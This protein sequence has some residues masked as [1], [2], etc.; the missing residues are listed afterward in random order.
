MQGCVRQLHRTRRASLLFKLDI[1]KAFDSVSWEYLFELMQR[2]GFSS[3]WRDWAALLLSTASSSCLLNGTAGHKF[4]H[5]KGL[6]QGDPLSPLLFILA[7]DPL[8]RLLAAAT[9]QGVLAPLPGRGVSMRVSLYA[10]DAVIFANPIKEEVETLLVILKQ[11][12]EATGLSLNQQKSTVA[13]IR[14]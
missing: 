2:M 13:P 8:H 4:Q 10:D 1:A 7:I 5:R 6:R 3:R 11:F 12:G 9:E 14:C